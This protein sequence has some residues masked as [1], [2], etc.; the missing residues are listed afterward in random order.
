MRLDENDIVPESQ[1]TRMMPVFDDDLNEK[2]SYDSRA[3]RNVGAFRKSVCEMPGVVTSTIYSDPTCQNSA[4][5]DEG[6]DMSRKYNL[7]ACKPFMFKIPEEMGDREGRG[8]GRGS[9]R[10]RLMDMDEMNDMDRRDGLGDRMER[11]DEEEENEYSDFNDYFTRMGN[12]FGRVAYRLKEEDPEAFENP[13]EDVNKKTR[14]KKIEGCSYDREAKKC[15]WVEDP[16]KDLMVY[17]T[18]EWQKKTVDGEEQMDDF[19]QYEAPMQISS[20]DDFVNYCDKLEGADE[21]LTA[22]GCKFKAG[23]NNKADTCNP[24]LRRQKLK[25]KTIGKNIDDS[26]KKESLCNMFEACAIQK[27]KCK[28]TMRFA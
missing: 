22:V 23:K 14:C 16:M 18:V 8:E 15:M 19:C 4:K 25:C 26:E 21:C 1:V 3:D 10:N 2:C 7:G 9:G 17:Y 12:R 24:N 5:D 20:L 6:N 27:N 13:C 28:G 11:M